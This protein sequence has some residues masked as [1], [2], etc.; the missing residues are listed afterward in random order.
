MRFL[1]LVLALVSTPA[2]AEKPPQQIVTGRAGAVAT[3]AAMPSMASAQRTGWEATLER[4]VQSVVAIRV[5]GTRNFDTEDANTS[6]GTGFV[7]DA[8]KGLILT[9]RHMV[10]AGPVVA[11][12]VFLNHEEVELQAIYRDPIHDFGV[13]R[14]DPKAVKHM[15]VTALRLVPSAARVGVEIRVVGND[16][17]EKISILDGTLARL[18]RNPPFYG[19]NTYNDFN[20]FYIQAASNT[21]GGSSGSPVVDIEGRV[22]ALNAGGSTAAASSFYLPLERVVA[23]LEFIDRGEDVPRGTLQSVFE[24]IPFDEARRLGLREATEALFRG[25]RTDGTGMLVVNEVLPEGPA[26]RKLEPGDLVLRV[27]GRIITT[28][29]AFEAILDQHVGEEVAIEVERGGEPIALTVQVGDLHAITPD[30]FL[31]VGRA[32]LHDVSFQ[33]ARNHGIPVRGVYVATSGYW[34]ANSGI[35]DGAL[36]TEVDGVAVPNLDAFAAE[37]AKKAD[38]QRIRLRTHPVEQHRQE[39]IAIATVDRRWNP[40]Q[41]CTRKNDGT[42]PCA[43]IP[44]AGAPAVGEVAG[45]AIEPGPGRLGRRLA[46]A[47]VSIRFQIPHPTS[48]LKDFN[49]RGAGVVVDAAKGLVLTDR[50]TVPVNLGDLEIS[51]GGLLRVPGRVVYLD[52]VH[53]VAVVQYDPRSIGS[54]RVVEI[55]VDPRPMHDGDRL[56]QIGVNGEARIVGTR[57]RI[58]EVEPVLTGIAGTPRYR[59]HNVEGWSLDTSKETVGGALVDCRGHLRA[60]W[61][62]F[63]DQKNEERTFYGLPA[64]FFADTI[65]ALRRGETPRSRLLGAEFSPIPL[66]EAIERGL[67][68]ERAEQL[69]KHDPKGWRVLQ[70]ERLAGGTSAEKYLRD[71]DLLLEVEGEPVTFMREL[72]AFRGRERVVLTVLRDGDEIDAEIEQLPV[73]GPGVDR[74]VVWAGAILHDPHLDAVMQ[75]GI[76]PRGAYLTW[77]WYGSPSAAFGLRP[78]RRIVE[79]DGVPTPDLDAFLAAVSSQRDRQSVRIKTET[80]DGKIQVSSLKM[81]LS[82]W[83]TT[84]IER[85]DGV[86]QRREVAAPS[87]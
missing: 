69:R 36:I 21:S 44:E 83:P 26:A 59:D 80:L 6:V 47:I 50:D 43:G 39:S 75:Q 35:D 5:S 49:F 51:F 82:Y 24:Y 81:D 8:S 31:E 58:A 68:S 66:Q 38:G 72:E 56:Y 70:V 46:P 23:A 41:R 45:V 77:M 16:A 9:N 71:G 63:V 30:D 4:V 61:A 86:W 67:S 52:P 3:S 64:A 14:F 42:W 13:Y 57:T 1:P 15:P 54:T 32:V 87:R 84:V 85:K 40:V 12:A 27:G 18:D 28:F 11:Q 60:L 17:G 10:H 29:A 78:T 20:T 55:P 2:F 65:A 76:A 79:V 73:E 37:L 53:N 62:S 25:E 22:V 33:Q 34:L 7:I 19:R 48:G 74:V